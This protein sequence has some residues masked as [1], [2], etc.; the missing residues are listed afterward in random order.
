MRTGP[1]FSRAS[2]RIFEHRFEKGAY[3]IFGSETEGLDETLRNAHAPDV[4]RIPQYD[5]RVRSLNLACA[6][7]I[8]VYEAIRQLG[9]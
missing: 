3:L 8:V 2:H 7:S 9:P 1:N 5:E 4:Y 6:A